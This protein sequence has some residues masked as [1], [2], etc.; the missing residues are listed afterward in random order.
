MPLPFGP[1]T[2]TTSPARSAERDVAQHRPAGVARRRST[3]GGSRTGPVAGGLPGRGRARRSPGRARPGARRAPPARGRPRGAR[4]R[5]GARPSPPRRRR[6]R[7]RAGWPSG[8]R[9]RVV[10]ELGG[11]LVEQHHAGARGEHRR[12]R[13]PLALAAGELA[14]AG[15]R[16]DATRPP[17]RGP[18]R[19]GP[20]SRSR[21]CPR[22]PGRR[23]RRAPT[24]PSTACASGSWKTIAAERQMRAGGVRRV[25][26]PS[27]TTRPPRTGR[28]GSGAPGRRARA[29]GSTCPRPRAPRAAAPRPPRHRGR[30]R[31]GPGAT[32][33][34]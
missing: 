9:R 19:R 18:R 12:E 29:G 15:A 31:R 26:C 20:G 21:G 28:R 30:R 11:R 32:A 6:P 8:P 17:S 10:V 1:E 3:P 2:A 27:T 33:P 23:R 34:P 16:A 25:S 13:D 7:A 5:R 24:E 22:S 14:D 4:G